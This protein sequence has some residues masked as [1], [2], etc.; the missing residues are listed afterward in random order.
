MYKLAA[1]KGI[2]TWKQVIPMKDVGK[3]VQGVKDNS[4]R[5]RYVI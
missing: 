3:G 4:V 5:Y 1:E 2:K